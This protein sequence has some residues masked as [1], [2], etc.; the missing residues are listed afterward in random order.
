MGW[1]KNLPLFWRDTL[2]RSAATFVQALFPLG[3]AT[4]V[5][6]WDVADWQ[7]AAVAATAAA[8]A[9]VKARVATRFGNPSTA[10]LVN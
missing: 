1:Y 2:E 8:L 4:A 9:V 7:Q 5:F 10:S 6:D 3:V